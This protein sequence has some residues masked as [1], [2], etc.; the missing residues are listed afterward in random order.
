LGTAAW[1]ALTDSS[2]D[3]LNGVC[4]S[5]L[6]LGDLHTVLAEPDLGHHGLL[7]LLDDEGSVIATSRATDDRGGVTV[8]LNATYK[9]V[10]DVPEFGSQC[11][12][13]TSH[14]QANV[15]FN[16]STGGVDFINAVDSDSDRSTLFRVTARAFK[17]YVILIGRSADF[18][19]GIR[20]DRTVAIAI[21][22]VMFVMAALT[23]GLVACCFSRPL[24]AVSEV[25]SQLAAVTQAHVSKLQREGV[26][27]T[28]PEREWKDL[29]R[30]I[31]GGS[32]DDARSAGSNRPAFS[33]I[34]RMMLSKVG[35]PEIRLLH[36]SLCATVSSLTDLAQRA[37]QKE[38]L[39][40]KFIRYIFHEVRVPLHSMA[41]ALAQMQPSA[42]ES[43]TAQIVQEQCKSSIVSLLI[44]SLMRVV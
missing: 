15:S 3:P 2:T 43:D 26:A 23:V 19:G 13:L 6:Y 31:E 22:V 41:L 16:S 9:H 8:G 29:I 39:R 25:L 24:M 17:G 42:M 1:F 5:W 38:Q 30:S 14:I 28:L 12:Q 4:Y 11:H 36:S 7:L 18:D 40:R 20:S 35:G 37:S 33:T 34:D 10:C 21:S 27:A 44:S 32:R